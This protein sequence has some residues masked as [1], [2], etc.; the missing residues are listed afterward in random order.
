MGLAVMSPLVGCAARRRSIVG[1]LAAGWLATCLACSGVCSTASTRACRSD[2]WVEP[3]KEMSTRACRSD[4]WVEPKK[5]MRWRRADAGG[6]V[7]A[8]VLRG[9]PRDDDDASLRRSSG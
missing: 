6:A 9:T 5:E 8:A 4:L 1:V 7:A 2:L 3:K